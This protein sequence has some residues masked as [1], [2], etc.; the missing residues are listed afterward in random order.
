MTSSTKTTIRPTQA[1]SLIKL[2]DVAA[3][4]DLQPRVK[5]DAEVVE[6]YAS[7]MQRGISFPPIIVFSD[8]EKNWLADGYHRYYAAKKAG[9]DCLAAE[10]RTGTK[11]DA[12]KFALS[13]NATHGLKRSQADKKRVVLMALKEF[14]ELSD[15]DIGRLVKVDG[16]TV[17]KYRAELRGEPS[18]SRDSAHSLEVVDFFDEKLWFTAQVID[19]FEALKPGYGDDLRHIVVPEVRR[20]VHKLKALG[21]QE[22]DGPIRI[23]GTDPKGITVEISSLCGGIWW[24]VVID[25]SHVSISS[26]G[27][28]VGGQCYTNNHDQR[29]FDSII[30]WLLVN[31][32]MDVLP[33][34]L[35]VLRIGK[36]PENKKEDFPYWDNIIVPET[37]ACAG[38]GK[39]V[40]KWGKNGMHHL[41]AGN[42]C[43]SCYAI[44]PT[45][46]VD[47]KEVP[48]GEA[49]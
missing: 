39:E 1:G 24:A 31:G 29:G 43:P 4:D 5:I 42:F 9:L 34:R 47:G 12:L 49:V 48:K 6:E 19:Q 38:C 26:D 8:G 40:R 37:A 10:F 3:D 44:Q 21:L 17:A 13:A 18:K 32:G 30:W 20:C 2:S 7:A 36:P 35:A 11:T 15:R 41:K 28:E 27:E 46:I 23:Q 14:G 33:S 22:I 25:D 45:Q 16:K